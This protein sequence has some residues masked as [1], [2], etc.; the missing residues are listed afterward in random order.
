MG[1]SSEIIKAFGVKYI[2]SEYDYDIKD[3]IKELVNLY[4]YITGK[5]IPEEERTF[6]L[7]EDD[8]GDIVPDFLEELEC[9]HDMTIH[10]FGNMICDTRSEPSGIIIDPE[11]NFDLLKNALNSIGSSKIMKNHTEICI[12]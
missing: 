6:I 12:G 8:W 9:Y 4:E 1:Q 5:K 3:T 7:D 11:N 10:H 2:L